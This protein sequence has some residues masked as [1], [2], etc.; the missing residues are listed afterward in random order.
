MSINKCEFIW[1]LLKFSYIYP[2]IGNSMHFTDYLKSIQ[3]RHL[4]DNR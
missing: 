3:I 4:L 2:I 1:F